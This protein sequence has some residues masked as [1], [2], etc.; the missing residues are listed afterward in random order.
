M[1][2]KLWSKVQRLAARKA[3]RIDQA[4]IRAIRTARLTYLSEAKLESIALTCGAL[5]RAGIAGRF[6]EAG[7][8]LGGSSILI[9]RTK[10]TER[11]FDVFDVFGMIPAPTADDPEDVQARYVQIVEGASAGIGGDRYYGYEDDL[12]DKVVSNLAR[13]GVDLEA[14]RVSLIKGLVQH[15]M[16]IDGPVAFAH[17]DV[18]WYEPVKTCLARLTPHLVRGGSLILDDYHDWGG[19][20][21]ATDEFLAGTTDRYRLD[22]AVGS[23]KLTR[24]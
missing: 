13:F 1:L 5:E 20:R 21:K 15:T 4:L 22:D 14:S 3:G 24:R 18:D 9:A 19:C 11:R 23:L 7:C 8:A 17:I 10:S 12:L 16:H 6:V 2:P